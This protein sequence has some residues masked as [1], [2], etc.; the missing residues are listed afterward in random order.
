MIGRTIRMKQLH[1]NQIISPSMFPTINCAKLLFP[2]TSLMLSES[3]NPP[4]DI[5]APSGRTDPLH[6]IP[7]PVKP[8]QQVSSCILCWR[9]LN[10]E[11]WAWQWSTITIT[12]SHAQDKLE[13]VWATR[14]GQARI[15]LFSILFYK[16]TQIYF[17]QTKTKKNQLVCVFIY[18]DVYICIYIN[19]YTYMYVCI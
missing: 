7:N 14:K 15:F 18:I 10:K 6:L 9:K 16:W 1:G 2:P 3:G 5:W 8:E 12:A 13:P 11:A 19:M 4:P 17:W